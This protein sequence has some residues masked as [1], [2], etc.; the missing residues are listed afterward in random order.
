MRRRVV[1]AY[2]ARGFDGAREALAEELS[3]LAAT[4]ETDCLVR[5][6]LESARHLAAR[7][8][9]HIDLAAARGLRSPRSLLVLL[10]R[11]HLW[12]LSPAR[13]LDAR[14]RP[15]QARGIAILAQDLPAIPAR[16]DP[17]RPV[18]MPE[19]DSYTRLRPL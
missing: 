2:D 6:L 18:A 9:C 15:L 12:G 14:A 17:V 1:A 5:H 8:Q 11:L 4:P 7:A 13:T 16:V 19:G 10:L 3:T